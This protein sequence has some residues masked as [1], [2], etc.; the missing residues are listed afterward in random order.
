MAEAAELAAQDTGS[1]DVLRQLD[2][3]RVPHGIW[4]Y[5]NPGAWLGERFGAT[6]PKTGLG[7][8]NGTTVLK[9]LSRSAAEIQEGIHDAV[10]IVGG[11]A[12]HSKRKAK[13]A[14]QVALRT[15]LSYP[16][17]DDPL[18]PPFDFHGSPD[19]QAGLVNATQC[20]GLFEVALR[21][22][23]GESVEAHRQRISAL[24]AGFA[25]VAAGNPYAWV[26]DAPTAEEIASPTGGNRI[27]SSPYNKYM[28]ANMV[29]DQ[30]AAV[31]LC[32]TEKARSLGIPEDRWVFPWVCTQSEVGK[33]LSERHRFD[34]EPTLGITA[35]H[36]LERSHVVP[37]DLGPID[38]YSCFPAAIQLA[39]TELEL[40]EGRPP[41][42][43][44]GLTFGGG[45]FNNY[46]IHALCQATEA[47]RAG[48]AK[49]ALVSGVGGFMASHAVM[50][51]GGESLSG[52][53]ESHNLSEEAAKL[54]G[55]TYEANYRGEVE[56]ETYVVP[57]E[58]NVPERALLAGRTPDGGRCWAQSQDPE[59]LKAMVAG[60]FC[61]RRGT[62]DEEREFVASH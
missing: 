53:F 27:I 34:E 16:P 35:R 38:L 12:E 24:W 60:E 40:P 36:T 3:I 8:I 61:G 33:S 30:S 25:Q 15:K 52:G 31:L 32:S 19:V 2:A 58:N 29:V 49:P 10:L 28:V 18:P 20:F 14:G 43:T 44:G 57:H 41:T 39:M 50:T 42:L 46:V 1:P 45:P 47:L 6:Q 11:E 62:V 23:A 48:R 9:M 55:R 51:L 7:V 59:L 26:R 13:A 54:P 21:H 56:I 5:E 37:A 4:E 17:A 22:R